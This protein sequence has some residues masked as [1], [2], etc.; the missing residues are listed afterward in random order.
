MLL[1]SPPGPTGFTTD[2][3]GVAFLASSDARVTFTPGPIF[4]TPAAGVAVVDV[5]AACAGGFGTPPLLVL[6]P[7]AA[8]VAA[9]R[10]TAV[11]VA[12]TELPG[13]AWKKKVAYV[14]VL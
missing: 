6:L 9:A 10:L 13:V 12:A 1:W 11:A 7:C 14:T 2:A 8:A 3:G 5:V 4:A